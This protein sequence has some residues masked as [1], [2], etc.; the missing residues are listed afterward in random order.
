MMTK[1]TYGSRP[2]GT[3]CDAQIQGLVHSGNIIATEPIAEGQIQPASMDLRLDHVAHQV[4][5]ARLPVTGETVADIVRRHGRGTF[6][7]SGLTLK[8]GS[9]WLVK[10]KESLKLD[11][12]TSATANGKST[13]GR[14]DIMCRLLTDGGTLY[15]KV[16]SEYEGEL[17]LE[18]APR[19]FDVTLHESDCL[20]QIRFH[21]GGIYTI[22]GPKSIKIDLSGDVAGYVST[23]GLVAY[24]KRDHAKWHYW[25]P[26]PVRDGEAIL[27]PGQFYVLRSLEPVV[28]GSD[29][30]AECEA[31]NTQYGEFRLHYAGFVDPGFNGRL[32]LEVRP[33]ELPIVIRHGQQIGQLWR[34]AMSQ[35]PSKLY[36]DAGNAYQSQTLKLAKQFC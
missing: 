7:S 31:V 22:D 36:G 2:V 14:L 25:S 32:V 17:W 18:V 3:L 33:F 13:A 23:G 20:A 10:C 16:Q 26:L 30:C 5:H 9:I 34:E 11:R 12:N 1:T 21:D 19:T 28:I 35:A 6:L 8:R 27:Y 24:D 15:N 29:E 4:P